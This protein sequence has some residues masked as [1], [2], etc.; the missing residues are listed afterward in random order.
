MSEVLLKNIKVLSMAINLPGPAACRSFVSLG[1]DV[2]K[3]EPLTG[4][5]LRHFSKAWYED[6][7]KGQK[8]I[9]MDLKD[10]KSRLEFENHL[11]ASDL[12]ITGHRPASLER[13]GLS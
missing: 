13:L 9:K 4:D 2:I 8:I 7:T 3:I 6:V 1:A 12:L 11:G 10:P 5:P